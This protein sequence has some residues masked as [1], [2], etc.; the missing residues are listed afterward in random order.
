MQSAKAK[1]KKEKK[2]IVKQI[3]K[4]PQSIYVVETYIFRKI[5][6]EIVLRTI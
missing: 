6:Y 5:H 1:T 2:F 3:S 4:H